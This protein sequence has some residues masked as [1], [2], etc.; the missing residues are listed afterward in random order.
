MLVHGAGALGAGTQRDC[1][2]E[3][4]D[5]AALGVLIV[6]K[7]ELELVVLSLFVELDNHL[8]RERPA[9]LGTETV[10]RADF[11]VAQ[12]LLDLGH[13]KGAAGWRLAEGKTA[14]FAGAGLAAAGVAAVVFLDDA[15][16]VGAGRL[17]RGVVAGNGVFV[18]ALSLIDQALGHA[19]DLGHKAFAAELA[20]LHLRE[21]VFPLTGQ[22]GA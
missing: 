10:Q 6:T 14:T 9:G 17:Q 4:D 20:Q 21:L 7:V 18:V 16:A 3:I 19:G 12:E 8:G 15:A 22:V 2:T 13:F 11:F 5:L 1:C